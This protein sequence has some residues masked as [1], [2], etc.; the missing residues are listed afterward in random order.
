[1]RWAGKKRAERESPVHEGLG[2]E[3]RHHIKD[4]GTEIIR[5][6][7]A[8]APAESFSRR[9][10]NNSP[11]HDGSKQHSVSGRE[12]HRQT[13]RENACDA[14]FP[15][16]MRQQ[17]ASRRWCPFL[18]WWARWAMPHDLQDSETRTDHDEDCDFSSLLVAWF[19]VAW[20]LSGQVRE[21]GSSRRVRGQRGTSP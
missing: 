19:L 16:G 18:L 20:P 10:K 1:M 11:G 2:E 7:T 3:R 6:V 13:N 9:I 21:T 15:S 17:A 4:C 14:G 8:G 12:M 5:H